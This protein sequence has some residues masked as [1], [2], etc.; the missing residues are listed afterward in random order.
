[1]NTKKDMAQQAVL[2][3]IER[4]ATYK[5]VNLS[6]SENQ[7]IADFERGHFQLVR[8]G[9]DG[10]AFA[11][12]TV[13][14]FDVK[15]DGKIWIQANNTDVLITEDLMEQGVEKSDIVLGFQPPRYRPHT[16]F[17]VS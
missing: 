12:S 4:F 16:G 9:W 3:I 6:D 11:H 1:M 5:P 2:A 10:D 8:I 7:V 13:F 14:H 15:P 17:A